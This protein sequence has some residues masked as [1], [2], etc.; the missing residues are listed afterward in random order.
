VTSKALQGTLA[1]A[2]SVHLFPKTN[3][4]A[5]RFFPLFWPLRSRGS[6]C[7]PA[8]RVRGGGSMRSSRSQGRPS[9][10]AVWLRRVMLPPRRTYVATRQS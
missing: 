4:E 2:M 5:G 3:I 1:A 10:A 9:A 6:Y 7:A 8:N